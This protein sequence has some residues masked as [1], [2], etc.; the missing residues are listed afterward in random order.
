ML[1]S[2]R[3]AL[4]FCAFSC[5][6]ARAAE[7]SGSAIAPAGASAASTERVLPLGQCIEIALR[8]SH[9]RPAS[10]FGLAMAEAQ[11][12][13]ALAGYWPQVNFKAGYEKLNQPLNFIFP[14]SVMPV[15]SQS[16]TVAGGSAMVTIPANFLAP[17]FPPSAMQVPVTFPSQNIQTP[18]Q[19]L[20]IPQENVKVLD[21]NVL[22]SSL[23]F[24]W[25]LYDGGMRSGY[26]QQSSGAIEMARQEVRR[27]DLEIT[28]SVKRYYWGAVLAH[29][30]RQLGE[31]TLAR[32]EVTLK[33]TESLYKEGSGKVTKADY[34]DNDVMVETVRSMVAHLEENEKMAE[35]ALS[36]TMGFNWTD[37][38]RPQDSDIPFAP[39]TGNLEELV[40]TSYRFSPDW[41]KLDN[42][43]MAAEGA[44]TTARSD[45]QPKIALTGELHRWWNG[46][47][48]SG[49]ATAENRA[50]WS[51][52]VGLEI[53]VFNGFLTKNKIAEAR[54]LVGQLKENQFLLREGLGLQVKSLVMGLD[55]A[56]K[57]DQATSRAM[58]SA[59]ENSDL[60]TRA[61][62]NGL[63][64]TEKV[65]RTQL[66]EA[67]MSAQHYMARYEYTS[68]LSQLSLVVGTEVQQKFAETH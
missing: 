65:L 58:K 25:L 29:Q 26:R 48:S 36:N 17:G 66:V 34:L 63:V 27:T 60:N 4:I 31:D 52:G 6:A 19:N 15:P 49:M 35:A 38:V 47:Y 62:E 2:L 5:A 20:L 3:V 28:D 54:A 13:Q 56:L 64:D 39:Y 45:Y 40:G 59:Q 8:Q 37:S 46:G 68:L 30:L 41:N 50:G 16:M 21:D 1:S 11:H 14:A 53:P 67:L 10:R 55:A 32:M 9:K 44:V 7:P 33:L 24:K 61:Y 23:D 12:R 22:S 51:T 42:A 57:S 43:L 18:A